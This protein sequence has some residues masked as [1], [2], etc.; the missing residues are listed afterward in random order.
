MRGRNRVKVVFAESRRDGRRSN[1]PPRP[2]CC[3]LCGRI[4]ISVSDI[5]DTDISVW[6]LS[7]LHGLHFFRRIA[8]G[9]FTPAA[10]LKVLSSPVFK[11]TVPAC[12]SGLKTQSS[13][14]LFMRH[15][16]VR[17]TDRSHLQSAATAAEATAP[18]RPR[19]CLLCSRINI[20]VPIYRIPIYLYGD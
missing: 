15:G 9:R 2:R 12:F 18:P 10:S 6:G 19:C 17:G 7:E 16:H 4:N 14:R 13:L 1:R 3:L 11:Q 8:D 20:S 5:S